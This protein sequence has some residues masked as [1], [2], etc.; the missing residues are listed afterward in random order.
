MNRIASAVSLALVLAT[1]ACGSSSTPTKTDGPPASP[2]AAPDAAAAMCIGSFST[3]TRAQLGALTMPAGKCSGSADLDLICTKNI[4][5]IA[6]DCGV[7]CVGGAADC[8]KTCVQPKAALSDAC[9]GCYGAVVTCAQKNCL[10]ACINDPGS[11]GCTQCQIDQGCLPTF[12]TC[13]GLPGAP[14]PGDGGTA[15]GDGGAVDASATGDGGAVDAS[16]T[17]DAAADTS[18]AADVAASSDSATD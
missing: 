8:F 18:A 11:Q 9:L 4:K 2:D 13:S 14:S 6:G 16:A 3:L 15:M 17:A 7:M 12:F 10:S 5:T 1:A